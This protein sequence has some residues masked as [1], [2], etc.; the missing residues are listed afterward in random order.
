MIHK[1]QLDFWT[2]STKFG[3]A[4]NILEPVEGQG[5]SFFGAENV[6]FTYNKDLLMHYSAKE[7]VR[8]TLF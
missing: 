4:Q 7:I 1:M 8:F 5:I 6:L 3:P 2:G